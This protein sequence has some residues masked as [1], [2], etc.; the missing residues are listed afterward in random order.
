M[1]R[2]D[3]SAAGVSDSGERRKRV[4]G[5]EKKYGS[6]AGDSGRNAVKERDDSEGK[7]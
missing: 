5:S 7:R 4:D 3:K 1:T 6:E 2:E